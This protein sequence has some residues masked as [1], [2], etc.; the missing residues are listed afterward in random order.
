MASCCKKV[1]SELNVCM[2]NLSLKQNE[3]CWLLATKAFC[4]VIQAG[5]FLSYPIPQG[6]AARHLSK[7]SAASSTNVTKEDCSQ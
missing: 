6:T 4:A 2:L 3:R 5:W 7:S 1:S